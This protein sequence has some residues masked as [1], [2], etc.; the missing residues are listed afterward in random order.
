MAY[1]RLYRRCNS[2]RLRNGTKQSRTEREGTEQNG[3]ET[4]CCFPRMLYIEQKGKL[5]LELLQLDV[6][7]RS[8][9]GTLERSTRLL[10]AVLKMKAPKCKLVQAVDF[11]GYVVSR[12]GTLETREGCYMLQNYPTLTDLKSLRS[13][14]GLT[15]YYWIF[16][17]SFSSIANPLTWSTL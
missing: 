13:F 9:S 12:S 17:H 3:M 1:W 6:H 8:T 11:L 10:R 16:I 2:I 15:S 14:Q 7:S 5:F 4:K